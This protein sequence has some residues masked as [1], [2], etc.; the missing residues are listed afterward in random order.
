[1]GTR[2]TIL[3]AAAEIMQTRGL[4]HATTKEIAKAAGFS[5]A[6]LYKHF[7][8]KSE[9]FLDVLRERLPTFSPLV[10]T[11]NASVGQRDIREAL[12]EVG[13]NAI[14]FYYE[15]FPMSAS[16]YSELR[17]LTQHRSALASRGA[18]P[19]RAN[20]GLAGY[21]RAEQKQGRI[22]GTAHPDAVAAVLLGACLQYAFLGTFAGQ[23][24]DPKAAQ[25]YV[26]DVVDTLMAALTPASDPG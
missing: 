2:D 3:D 6:T 7:R 25:S 23:P 17:L 21:L 4:A 10:A 1:M 16:V 20:E 11:L 13:C 18:G 8:D 24:L 5:E 15:S 26:D 12:V 19:H 9:I 14:A 22:A